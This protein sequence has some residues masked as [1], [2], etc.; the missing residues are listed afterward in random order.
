M[1]D[2]IMARRVANVIRKLKQDLNLTSVVV[3]HDTRL[4]ERVANHII[5]LDNAKVL[6]YGTIP[7]MERARNPL[8]RKFLE[9]D[10]IDLRA[11]FGTELQEQKVS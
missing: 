1:V 6:F 7:E 3:T 8:V 2:P 9:L 11:L 10:R 4:A 5:F